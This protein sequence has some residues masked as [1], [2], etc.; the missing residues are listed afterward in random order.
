MANLNLDQLTHH[1]VYSPFFVLRNREA[2]REEDF[3]FL[4]KQE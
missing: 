1:D 4:K 2:Q 3:F